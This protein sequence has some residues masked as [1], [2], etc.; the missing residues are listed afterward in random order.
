MQAT[1]LAG[2]DGA[3]AQF[4]S[5]DGQ[6]LGFFANGKLNKMSVTGGAAVPLCDAPSGRGGTWVNDDTII[7]APDLVIGTRL[8]RVSSAGGTPEPFSSLGKDGVTQRWPQEIAGRVVLYTEHSRVDSF[9][10]ANLVVAPLTGGAPKIVAR[11][12]YYGR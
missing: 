3:S 8:L 12:G 4:F 11:G 7:F 2:T 10:A 1:A 5:P 6:W 9:D